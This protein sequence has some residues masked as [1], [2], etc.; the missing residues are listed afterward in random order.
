[1]VVGA[2]VLF[3]IAALLTFGAGAGSGSWVSLVRFS[4]LMAG[5]G[6]AAAAW[7]TAVRIVYVHRV[8]WPFLV[9]VGLIASA[10]LTFA[11]V[12]GFGAT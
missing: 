8:T 1:L 10:G 5:F 3:G 2:L 4:I 11:A 7:A 12:L 9:L 6:A